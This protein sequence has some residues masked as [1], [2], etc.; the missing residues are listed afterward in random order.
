MTAE[1]IVGLIVAVALLGYLVLAL[2]FPE[3]F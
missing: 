1:N 2:I 3:R